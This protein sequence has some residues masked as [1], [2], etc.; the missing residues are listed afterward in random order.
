MNNKQ[1]ITNVSISITSSKQ[2]KKICNEALL[3]RLCQ[4]HPFFILCFRCNKCCFGAVDR[5][6]W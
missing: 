4:S 3:H 1:E 6:L 5:K 2:I